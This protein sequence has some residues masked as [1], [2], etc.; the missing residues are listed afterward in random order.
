MKWWNRL[1]VRLTVFILLLAIVPLAGFGISTIQDIR[2]VRLQSVAEI[3]TRVAYNSAKLIEVSLSDTV[4][5][6]QLVAEGTELESAEITDQESILQ[7]LISSTPSL[8]TLAIAKP[9]GREFVKIGRDTIYNL[10]DFGIDADH[11]YFSNTASLHSTIGSLYKNSDNLLLLNVNIPL[12]SAR[13]RQVTAVLVVEIDMEKLVNFIADLRVGETGYVYVVNAEGQYIAYPDHSAVLAGENALYNPMVKDFVAGTKN[14]KNNGTYFNRNNIKVIS[15]AHEV[16]EPKLLIVVAQ[17]IEEALATVNLISKRQT[18]LLMIVLAIAVL[19]S[20]YFSIKTFKPLLRLQSGAQLIGAGD[21]SH[22][23]LVNSSNELGSVTESFNLMA[24]SLEASHQYDKQQKWLE[25]G[26]TDLDNQLRGDQSQEQI[27]AN[28]ITFIASYLKQQVGLMYIYDDNETF[29]YTAGYA[30]QPGAGFLK[31]FKTGESL[32]GQA[33][34]EKKILKITDLPPDYISVSSGIGSVVPNQLVIVP[35]IYN[36]QVEAVIEIGAIKNLNKS[37]NQFL[38]ETAGSIAIILASARSRFELNAALLQTRQQAEELYQQQEALQASNEEL[39]EQTQL[40]MTSESKL[41]EQ[42]EELQAAN[43]EL[44]EKTNYLERHKKFIE[45]KNKSLEQLRKDLEQKATDLASASKYKSEFL[46]NMSHELRTPLNSL[47]LLSG[48]LADNKEGNL[49]EEQ[50]ESAQIIHNSGSDL[51][52]LINEIL[53]LS[54][55][56]AGKME[57]RISEMP[58]TVLRDSLNRTFRQLATDKGL[59]FEITISTDTPSTIISDGQRIEQILK[60]F[61]ANSFKFTSK[62]GVVVKIY[63]PDENQVFNQPNLTCQNTLAFAVI[64]TGIGIPEDQKKLIFEAFQQVQSGSN[65]QYGGT[66]LGLSISRELAQLLGG[67]IQLETKEH[68]GSIFTLFLPKDLSAL[69]S[70]LAAPSL[71]STIPTLDSDTCVKTPIISIKNRDQQYSCVTDDKGCF[72]PEDKSVLIIEDDKNFATTLL[73]F[74]KDKGFKVLV[75][76][77]GEEGLALAE[78]H[79]P[80]AIIL[81]IKLPGIDGWAVLE[82]LK[83]NPSMRHIPVHFMSADSPV[84]TAFIKGAIGYLTK[85]V[86]LEELEAALINLESVISKEMKDILLVEDNKNQRR[87]ICKLI[88]ENDVVIDEVANGKDAITALH[89]THYDCMILDLGLPDMSG[90]DLLKKLSQDISLSLPPIIVY[91]G[92][93]LSLEEENQLRKYSESIIIK[94][95]RSEERLLDETSLFLHRIV[96]KMSK[97]K[98]QMISSLHDTDQNLRG[99]NIL[100]VDDDMRNVFALSKVL[101]DKGINTIKAEN[102]RKALE[103]LDQRDDVDLVLMD[104]M[105][106]QMDG[107]ETIR[108]I[109]ARSS[110]AQL[111]ILALTAKAMQRDKDDCIAAGANDYLAKPVDINRLLSMMRVWLYR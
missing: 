27:C 1:S 109:R 104:I 68:T 26:I 42:Q 61:I 18:I 58:L 63:Q 55:I 25:K 11:K 40:L 13:D 67:E 34:Y 101:N 93:E 62:G 64:D 85:P 96:G 22:R 44:E 21:L 106:P 43:E 46:A 15:N 49:F 52:S 74:C 47:L 30:F 7:L 66:G 107:Y 39:E 71:V 79:Q 54:K 86:S 98:R 95:V 65:R 59:S 29:R 82:A 12:L 28:V 80:K 78:T 48:L 37:E 57:L 2:R 6:I 72:S 5:K 36:D 32:L 105:M 89:K 9:D 35:C 81:D 76:H 103:I 4:K 87:A 41:K 45:E 99:R 19:L 56:E 88:G 102:G 75:A 69:P 73:R 51:L 50:I 90:F 38:E 16:A 3:H 53:D 14:K 70:P 110:F 111:P 17:P 108:R 100:I 23:I 94:G 83:E 92:K 8:Y 20:L 31:S 77:T 33:A 10:E 60:N 84:Q 91:T 97:E 24:E